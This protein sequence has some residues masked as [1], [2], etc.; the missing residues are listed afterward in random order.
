[1]RYPKS[2]LLDS[3]WYMIGYCRFATGQHE[4]A[5]EMCRKVA[6]AKRIDPAT[7]REV[8]SP[9]K[10]QAIYILGQV[11]HS[12]G[13]AADA[14]RE[15]RRVEDRF[16][17]AKEAIEYFL[18]KGIELPEVTTI[19]PGG[20][21]RSGAEVPQ[22]RRLRRQGLSHRPDEVQ[23]PEAE[24]GRHR[25]RSTWPASAR[26]HETTVKLGDGKDYR[27]RTRKLTLPLKEE[28]AYLVVCRGDDLH[29]SG[30][31][32]V[33]PLAVEVQED[34]VSGRV[35]TTVKDAEAGRTCQRPRQG[36][37]QPQRRFRLRPDRPARHVRGRRHRGPLDRDRPRGA[38][39]VCLLSRHG[40]SGPADDAGP[41]REHFP[42][43]IAGP[44]GEPVAIPAPPSA[45]Y[46]P[47][48]MPTPSRPE[49]QKD[50]QLLDQLQN[51]NKEIQG[52][53]LQDLNRM[54]KSNQKG[55]EAEKAF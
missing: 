38:V 4:A 44:A 6:E 5:L 50:G 40:R 15:Y 7:G 14:I 30:L 12:L 24:P 2:E 9:N 3:Y 43:P 46:S 42:C 48:L 51:T 47:P 26:S 23:P 54:Y 55:V 35:R 27:D 10:W 1:M 34:A 41:E 49:L 45:S 52:K 31:V 8:E 28:G 32:L 22:H 39:A 13:E 19:K 29:A 36:D 20:R 11:Y 18:R 17:D 16:T 25:R 37:R 33:T 21:P 53:Q